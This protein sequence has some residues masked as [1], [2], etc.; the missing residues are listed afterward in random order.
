MKELRGSGR[1]GGGSAVTGRF[2][3]SRVGAGGAV[4][5]DSTPFARDSAASAALPL[6]V[7]GEVIAGQVRFSRRSRLGQAMEPATALTGALDWRVNWRTRRG[8][9]RFSQAV[10][11]KSAVKL[12]NPQ[13][14]SPSRRAAAE[15]ENRPTRTRREPLCPAARSA[16]DRPRCRPHAAPGPLLRHLLTGKGLQLDGEEPSLGRD[17]PAHDGEQQQKFYFHVPRTEH[18]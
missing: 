16:P 6:V 11:K 5:G 9:W 3:A 7:G 17:L 18:T 4:I 13:I 14:T 8:E 1:D 15:V 10:T 2:A 12:T